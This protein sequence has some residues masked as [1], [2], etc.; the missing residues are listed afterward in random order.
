MSPDCP[1]SITN[2]R[3]NSMLKFDKEFRSSRWFTRASASACEVYAMIQDDPSLREVRL[4]ELQVLLH[5]H[6]MRHLLTAIS[7][8]PV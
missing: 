4:S 8:A 6:L 7:V 2:T 3:S 1:M 5:L